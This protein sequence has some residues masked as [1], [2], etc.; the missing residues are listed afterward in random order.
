MVIN[1]EQPTVGR[2]GE[3]MHIYVHKFIINCTEVKD[4]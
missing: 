1:V 4:M 3:Y 2:K